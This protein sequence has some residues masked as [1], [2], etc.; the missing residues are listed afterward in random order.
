MRD[1]KLTSSYQPSNQRTN[2]KI[3]SKQDNYKTEEANHFRTIRTRFCRK[4][5]LFEAI[6]ERPFHTRCFSKGAS[7]TIRH[8]KSRE[9]RKDMPSHDWRNQRPT[10]LRFAT[11]DALQQRKITICV[12]DKQANTNNDANDAAF[13]PK[14]RGSFLTLNHQ[15]KK[16][17]HL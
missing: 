10:R 13:K 4:H 6:S 8:N 7:K 16:R 15:N 2:A 11:V 5:F 12:E 3:N 14:T 17:E 9:E 1:D